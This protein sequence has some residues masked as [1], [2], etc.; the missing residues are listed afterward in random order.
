MLNI[1]N[2]Q[3][4]SVGDG[5]G[6]RT[7]VFFKG[8]NLCC[9]WCH[10]PENLSAKPSVLNYKVTNKTEIVGKFVYAEDIIDELLDDK[11]YY[12]ES[13]GGITLSGGEVMLQADGI[14]PLLK[15]LA[16]NEVSVLIDTAGCVPYAGFQKINPYPPKRSGRY[17]L[18]C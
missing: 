16:E 11:D 13:N 17:K 6:I 5:D 18:R 10:N 4:F 14:V 7:T 8:C 2:I 3:H 1:S 12:E 15:L 9:P